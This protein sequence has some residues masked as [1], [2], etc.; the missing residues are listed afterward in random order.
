LND[1]V[2]HLEKGTDANN[3]MILSFVP[4]VF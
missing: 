3:R 1:I 2:L 4:S